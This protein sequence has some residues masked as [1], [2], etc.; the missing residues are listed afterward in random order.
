M[1]IQFFL[2]FVKLF[3][4]TIYF[5]KFELKKFKHT[6]GIQIVKVEQGLEK[7]NGTQ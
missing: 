7:L 4:R 5:Y 3:K 6:L 2:Y 1:G